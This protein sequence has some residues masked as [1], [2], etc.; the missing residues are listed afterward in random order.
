MTLLLNLL[1]PRGIHQSS[2][3]R[4]TD[5]ATR[6]PIED[7]FGSKQLAY[8]ASTWSAQI[9]FTG[10]A[11]IGQ[12]KTRDW[13]LEC[14]RRQPQSADAAT[15]LSGLASRAA[16]ELRGVPRKERFLTIVATVLERSATRLF[17]VSC[18]DRPGKPP[19]NQPLD[20]FEVSEV[21][22]STPRVLIFGSTHT[23]TKADRKFLKQ[24]SRGTVDQAEIRRALAR[25]NVRSAIRSNGAVSEGCLVTSTTPDGGSA[26]EN[27]GGTPGLTVDMAG[28][29]EA[30][31]VISEAQRGKR[32]VFIQSKGVTWQGAPANEMT[33][34]PPNM[35]KGSTMVVKLLADSGPLFV[36]DDVGNTLT[37]V[38]KPFDAKVVDQDAEWA[39]FEARLED[40]APAGPAR[41]IAFSSTSDSYAFNGPSGAKVGVMEIMG[42]KGDAVVMKNRVTRIRLG[43][44]TARAFPTFEQPAQTMKT[45]WDIR[46]LPTIDGAQPHEWR[47]TVDM[48][49]DASGGKLSI[50][51]N[52]VA[53]RS[54]NFSSLSCL[55]DTEELVVVSSMRPAAMSISKDQP[56]ASGCI[57]ARL[58]LRAKPGISDK[59]RFGG[60]TTASR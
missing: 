31:D 54:S 41:Y 15:A 58:F 8:V 10:F 16:V 30:F 37:A 17:V 4:L 57:E 23:V 7:E 44:V 9:S 52:S 19:P 56:Y 26:S 45:H 32:P 29:A 28:S 43:I 47:Y 25:I 18:T 53:L 42:S 14:L 49:L 34:E 5:L 50:R 11:Q 46:S 51:Q 6:R 1:G 36:T 22:T 2:D 55:D 21:S 40:S 13:I 60:A 24:L 33:F 3:Y 20:H 39:Q 59:S 27:Y 48:L 35:S 38:P 12:R